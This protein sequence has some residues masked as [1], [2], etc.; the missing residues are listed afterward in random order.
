MRPLLLAVLL[1]SACSDDPIYVEPSGAVEV[2]ADGETFT[3]ASS[4]LLPVRLERQAEAEDR[5]ARAGEL[6][7]MVPFVLRDDLDI[8][9]EWTLK[10]LSDAPAVARVQLNGANEMFA[11][12]PTAF[13]VDIE[14]E[15]VPPPLS[16]DVP[17]EMEPGETRD[18]VF[19]EDDLA[20]AALD[21]ELI[22]RGAV[23]PFAALLE[24]NEEMDEFD[25]AGV[26]VPSDA[27]ASL[28]RIDVGLVADQHMVLE[29]SVRVRDHRDLLH[30]E[31]ADAPP[32]ELTAFAPADY[33]PPAAP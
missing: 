13:V 17:L 5:A 7:V 24:V 15:E 2:G 29:Y 16:G 3:A 26:E 28:V 14:E 6:G 21:L 22:T 1:A 31:L 18:G 9:V 12:V 23:S 8:S 19:R 25:A 11:Y 27:F 30:D 4:T 32:E 20:E 10:N 33:A